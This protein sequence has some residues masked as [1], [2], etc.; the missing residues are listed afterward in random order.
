MQK[1]QNMDPLEIEIIKNV[2]TFAQVTQK[3]LEAMFAVNCQPASPNYSKSGIKTNKSLIV[4]VLFTGTVFGEF[5]L[6]LNA[7]TG[8]KILGHTLIGKD[9]VEKHKLLQEM[10]EVFSEILNL[11]VGESIVEL[12]NTY[13]KLT[14]TAPKVYFGHAIYPSVNCGMSVLNCAFGEIECHLYVDRM[15]LDI[16]SSYEEAMNSLMSVNTELRSAMETLETQQGILIQSEKMAALGTMAAGVA[17]EINTPLSTIYLAEGQLKDMLN[18]PE[19]DL[20]RQKFIKVLN[21]ISSTTLRIASITNSLKAY[22]K[23]SSGSAFKITS[24]NHLIQESLLFCLSGIQDK[25]IEL[26]ID[27]IPESIKINCRQEQ[28]AQVIFNILNNAA[29]A[30]ESLDRK[31]IAVQAKETPTQVEIRI[32]DS[33]VDLKKEIKDKIFDPFFTTKSLGKGTGLGMSLAK[34]IIDI[35]KGCLFV[36]PESKHT[37]FVIQFPKAI[38]DK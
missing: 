13:K 20:D 24:V 15:K 34:G 14:I 23:N 31:W 22:A 6:A 8:A 4:S 27:S 1:A 9:E 7:E 26:R 3:N 18:A 33:G 16:A 38:E 2:K 35:H 19:K 29:D 37:E 30:V 12:T 5:V 25:G 21:V 10:S 11:T 17:H 28:I 36:E 32:T